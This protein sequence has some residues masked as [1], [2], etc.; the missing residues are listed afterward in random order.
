MSAASVPPFGA[1]IDTT[2]PILDVDLPTEELK[3]TFRGLF[4]ETYAVFD[5]H[6][7]EESINNAGAALCRHI[8]EQVSAHPVLAQTV[9]KDM[10][11]WSL[12]RVV[13]EKTYSNPICHDAIKFL[14]QM[15]PHALFWKWDDR[16]GNWEPVIQLIAKNTC[17]CVLLPWIAQHFLWVFQ[18]PSC[19]EDPPHLHLVDNYANTPGFDADIVR[20]FY[21]LF[22]ACLAEQDED[23]PPL[24]RCIR[25]WEGVMRTFLYGWLK[26]TL[27]PCHSKIA[28]DSV[29]CIEPV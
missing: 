4:D 12:L 2:S 6:V 8:Q 19:R 9:A 23:G 29:L 11:R 1:A 17:H 22:P 7:D 20:Q 3:T 21:E 25:G 18:H 27:R 14:I 13:C 24:Q 5:D 15:N 26:S 16:S 28:L 10:L